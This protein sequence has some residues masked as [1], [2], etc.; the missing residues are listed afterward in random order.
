ML[1]V[2]T[3]FRLLNKFITKER[4]RIL[5][6]NIRFRVIGSIDNI[7]AKT[8]E[9]IEALQRDSSDNQ[10]LNLTFAFDY[11]ARSE[12]IQAINKYIELNPGKTIN[13]AQLERNLFAPDRCD[14]DLLIRTGGD[15]RISNF[16]LWQCTY[17]ELYFTQTKWP[18][19]SRQEFREI[20]QEVSS[21]ERRYGGLGSHQT[22]DASKINAEYNKQTHHFF[23]R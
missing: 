21:R 10:G 15:Q 16:M 14:V 8:K 7:P 22:L 9:L 17:S 13:E 12:I 19:F 23:I 2:Q 20:I 4:N 11:G 6:N 3:L 5:K 1:E 18:D